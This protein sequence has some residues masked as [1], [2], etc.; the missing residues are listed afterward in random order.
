MEGNQKQEPRA[1]TGILYEMESKK[2]RDAERSKKKKGKVVASLMPAFLI[3]ILL[4]AGMEA[5][6]FLNAYCW[7]FFAPLCAVL[8]ALPV[9]YMTKKHKNIG[10]FAAM[11][12]FWC[13]VTAVMGIK[14]SFSG[15]VIAII[16]M[17][18]S[19][20]IRRIL[21]YGSKEGICFG[22][23]AAALLPLSH[24]VFLWTDTTDYMNALAKLA[25]EKYVDKL[26]TFA[27]EIIL[28][29]MIIGTVAVGYF[30]ARFAVKYIKM[31]KKSPEEQA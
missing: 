15:L 20:L 21:G 12:I 10:V 5:L 9:V 17:V 16:A 1:K 19:E 30:S 31:D 29:I 27:T 6:S 4:I 26:G 23:G 28:F 2:A 8:C 18:V 24:Q 14:L 25:G 22:Y 7:V 3:Y 11:G 13:I